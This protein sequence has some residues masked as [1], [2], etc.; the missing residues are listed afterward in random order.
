MK[1]GQANIK[2]DNA[3]H[4]A[5]HDIHFGLFFWPPKYGKINDNKICDVSL[6]LRMI[7]RETVEYLY[8]KEESIAK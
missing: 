7:P 6:P 4:T 2:Q 5:P 1:C 3:L 8:L